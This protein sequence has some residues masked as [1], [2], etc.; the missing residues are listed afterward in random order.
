MTSER[1]PVQPRLYTE[2]ADWYPLLTPPE[3]YE[4]EAGIYRQI[5]L[6]AC[7]P[8]VP[9]TVLE[10][11]AGAGHNASFL[12]HSFELTLT[13]VSPAMLDLS[14]KL[15][16]ECAHVVGDMRTLRLGKQFDC[17]FAHDAVT[18]MTTEADL[19]A[20]MQTAFEHTVEGGAALFAPDFTRETFEPGGTDCGGKDGPD[21]ALR[22]LEWQWDPDPLDTTVV[23][24]YAY[25]LRGP[26][27]TVEVERDRHVLGLF[28]R[29]TWLRL[30]SEVGFEARAVPFTHS[31]VPPGLELFL[32]IK[33]AG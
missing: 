25:L 22:Y 19:R 17:V 1:S 2:L 32:G 4:E 13:D 28:P 20:A 30:L 7:A 14:R 18:Y 10:L 3:E 21:R 31:Q 12:K 23:A 5:L 16:P 33:R 6:D 27:G 29:A 24:D 9:R 26:D 15:N 11:G 8:R